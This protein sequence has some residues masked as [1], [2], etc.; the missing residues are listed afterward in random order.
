M[1]NTNNV[2]ASGDSPY[3]INYILADIATLIS[4]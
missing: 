1:H 2:P 3:S 4:M